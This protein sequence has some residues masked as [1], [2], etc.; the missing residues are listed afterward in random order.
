MNSYIARLFYLGDRYYGS[1]FQPN[2]LTVQGELIDALNQ[3]DMQ[4]ETDYSTQTVQ[5]SGRTDRGVHSIGQIV[6]IKTERELNIDK[7]NRYLPSDIALW[8]SAVVPANFNPRYD[9]LMRHYRYYFD[10]DSR[11][12]NLQ[13]MRNAIQLLSGTRDFSLFSKPDGDRPTTT[14]ILNACLLES[15]TG[16]T[17]DIFGTNFLWKLIRKTVSMLIQIGIGKL[18]MQT[19][20][21]HLN[22]P[23]IIPG[24]IEPAPPECLVLVE[25]AIPIRM[26]T[27]KYALSRIRKQLNA[28]LNYL[29]R[30]RRVLSAISDDYFFHQRNPS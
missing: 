3:W 9:V 20:S 18:E 28:H 17:M 4:S 13:S 16:I 10:L 30:S 25:T 2:L 23:G 1:Q 29:R 21:N 15:D 5:L 12:V 22:S 26:T 27:S 14:T 19:F 24:G 8:A 11:E 6:S 7:V